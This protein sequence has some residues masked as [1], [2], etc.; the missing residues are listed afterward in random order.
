MSVTAANL[1]SGGSGTANDAFRPGTTGCRHEVDAM[2]S[3]A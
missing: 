2:F 3:V 1:P